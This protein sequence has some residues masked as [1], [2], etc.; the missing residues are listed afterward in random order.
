MNEI[1]FSA[2]S[3]FFSLPFLFSKHVISRSKKA[4]KK[5]QKKNKK[6]IP[7]TTSF[8]NE[9]TVSRAK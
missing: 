9:T 2:F 4:V 1:F 3:V 5:E 6:N 8:T 7:F